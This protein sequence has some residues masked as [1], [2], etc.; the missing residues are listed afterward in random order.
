MYYKYTIPT[1][2]YGF[3]TECPVCKN[4]E[5]SDN[6][7][8]CRICGQSRLNICTESGNN[9]SHVNPSNARYCEKCGAITTFFQMKIL[10][11]WEKVP[12]DLKSDT[13]ESPADDDDLPF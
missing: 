6:A 8:Y 12:D 5:F 4:T 2:S 10:P 3:L 1:D 13:P 7:R 9:G 11:P